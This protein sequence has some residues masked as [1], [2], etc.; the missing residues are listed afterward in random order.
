MTLNAHSRNLTVPGSIESAKVREASDE[1]A[2]LLVMYRA[3][4]AELR[5]A[6]I[7]YNAAANQDR[8]DYADALSAGKSDPGTPNIDKTER[9]R[10]QVERKRAALELAIGEASAAV[11]E[12]VL[13]DRDALLATAAQDVDLAAKAYTTRSTC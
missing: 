1:H 3:T 4:D 2:R 10:A 9:V 12:A 6:E 5:N 8:R 13:D 7:A 11:T